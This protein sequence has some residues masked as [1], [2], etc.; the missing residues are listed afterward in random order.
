MPE[1]IED[2]KTKV[3]ELGTAWEQFKSANDARL[4]EIEKKGAADPLLTG[5]LEKINGFMDEAKGKLDKLET[6]A[7]RPGAGA[8]ESKDAT[9]AESKEQKAY[10]AGFLSYL[11]KGADVGLEDLQI[12]AMSVGSDPD[13][14]YLVTPAMS[15]TINKLVFE[16]TPMRALA[17][18]ETIS[19]DSLDM[20]DDTDQPTAAWTSETGTVSETNTPQIG[21]R[22]IPVHEL[23]AEPRATQK[24]LD[25]AGINVESWLANKVAE[26]FA[27]KEATAFVT[28]TGTGQPRGINTYTAGTTWGTIQQI[29]SGT[30]SVVYADKLLEMFYSLKDAYTP[31]ATWLMN[32][33]IALQIRQLKDSTGQY[34]WQPGLSAGNPDILL[35]RPVAWAADMPVAASNSLSIA[36]GDFKKGY[37]IVDRIGIRTLRD[38]FT[39]KPYVKFYTTK[40]VG[41]DVINFEAIKLMKLGA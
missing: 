9:G 1:P 30:S 13:G 4:E 2:I 11:R 15:S 22:N 7:A 19:T 41:G 24:L 31:N 21:K 16:S 23:Y 27:R 10:N 18:V 34:L 37:Q 36:L 32:R 40:R 14:G 3:E 25:D 5:Q 29:A 20:I 26:L 33:L 8:E 6:A 17:A 12:K 39:A 35:S 38:P 28:G